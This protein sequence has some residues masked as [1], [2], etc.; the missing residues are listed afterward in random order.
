MNQLSY[1]SCKNELNK[2]NVI[3]PEKLNEIDNINP[4][5]GL[6]FTEEE[7]NN[8]ISQYKR[9][10][11]QNEGLTKNCC[12]KNMKAKTNEEKQLLKSITK[13]FPSSL[14][15]NKNGDID[16]IM[17]SK[18]SL[19]KL[20]TN[21]MTGW[22]NT[23][24]YIICKIISAKEIE[25]NNN[26]YKVFSRLTQD[27]YENKC[28]TLEQEITLKNIIGNVEGD[29]KHSYL[30][31]LS[32]VKSIKENNLEGV[33][34]YILKYKVVDRP[35]THD[36]N[37]DTMLHLISKTKNL[38]MLNFLLS[39]NANT[40]A[41]NSKGETP[42]FNA[43]KFNN[44]NVIDRL[45]QQNNQSINHKNNKGETPIFRAVSEGNRDIL[46]YL[47]NKGAVLID[48]NNKG[49]NLVQHSIVNKSNYNLISFLVKRGVELKNK[50][51]NGKTALD[52]INEKIIEFKECHNLNNNNNNTYT[53][54]NKNRKIKH[55]DENT[56]NKKLLEL[57]S[58]QTYINKSMFIE[59][60]DYKIKNITSNFKSSP[61]EIDD[62]IC[63]K[64]L[65]EENK[66]RMSVIN[67]AISRK[68]CEKKGG[69]VVDNKDDNTKVDIEYFKEEELENI[70]K[71]DLNLKNTN[72]LLIRDKDYSQE[73]PDNIE[74]EE[75]FFNKKCSI[76]EGFTNKNIKNKKEYTCNLREHSKLIVIIFLLFLICYF[77][78]NNK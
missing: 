20:K 34:N 17:L 70:K 73:I 52:L 5:T 59:N 44:I 65:D 29:I 51:N 31:D 42:I 7:K 30:D 18:Y 72:P 69:Y 23:D 53:R 13:I 58:I 66:D 19:E 4:N 45:L 22:V 74:E 32:L 56:Y 54:L 26:N 15:I 48:K 39:L 6:P 27:C 25:T 8:V 46:L 40:N 14:I 16:K 49:N 64:N 63:Y 12:K 38:R 36:L 24:E 60:N 37:K 57:E 67:N 47:Y 71:E 61:V 78:I 11:N 43:I 10:C 1:I 55:L 33:K 2:C 3:K 41:K 62:F 50:N 75:S 68:D 28:E 76:H 21:N 9:I 35:L 77:I